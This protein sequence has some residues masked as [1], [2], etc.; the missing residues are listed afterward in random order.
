MSEIIAQH[1]VTNGGNVLIYQIENEYGDQW[2]NVAS[3]IPDPPAISYME[4]LES[5][6]RNAGINIPLTHNNPNMNTKPWST[7]YGA[8]VG[9][10]VNVY[11]LDSDPSCWSCNVA[12]CTTTNGP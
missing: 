6:A 2:K 10:D 1:Q 7:D 8:G 3:K 12:E 11:G 4:L 5:C 9:G